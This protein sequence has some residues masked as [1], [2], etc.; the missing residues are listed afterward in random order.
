MYRDLRETF[1]W[2]GMKKEIA[3]FVAQCQQV[4]AKYQKLA[5]PLQSI[6]ILEWKWEHITMDFVIK[7]PNSP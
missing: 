7:L 4:K 1:W 6:P 3:K 2:P 5:G